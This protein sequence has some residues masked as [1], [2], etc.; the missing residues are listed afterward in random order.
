[1]RL[2]I[3]TKLR[4][5]FFGLAVLFIGFGTAAIVRMSMLN[6]RSTE[7]ET[8]W[9]PSMVYTAALHIDFNQIMVELGRHILAAD[10]AGMA[11][12]DQRI[13]EIEQDIARQRGHYEPLI[14]ADDEAAAYKAFSR[15][16]DEVMVQIRAVLALS[17]TNQKQ[18]A[19][20][21]MKAGEAG[22]NQVGTQLNRLV[23]INRDGAAEEGRA[24]TEI[25]TTTRFRMTGGV[26]LVVALAL[27]LAV[28]LERAVS[29]P[30]AALSEVVG[31]LAEGDL[32]VT[33]EGLERRDEVG[34]IARSVAATAATLQ[35]LVGE[36]R[37]LIG[38]ARA[39]N[40][41][42]RA[43]PGDLKGDYAELLLGTNELLDV[44]TRPLAE[45][46]QVMQ[47]LASGDLK[48]RMTGAYEGDLRALKNNV[49]RS[50]DG[51]VSLLTELGTLAAGMAVGD[52]RRTLK[53]D[54]QG[55]FASLTA[56]FNLA[57]VK[58]RDAL[59]ALVADTAQ[60]SAA[61]SQTTAAARQVAEATAGQMSTLGEI[62]V[63]ISQTAAAVNE[64]SS[65]AGTGS[66]LSRSTAELAASGREMLARLAGEV[67]QIAVRQ[68]SID[69]ITATITRIADKTQVLSINAGIEAAR[70]GEQGRGF[71]VVA[72]EIGRLAEETALAA[73][74]IGALILEAGQ[75]VQRTVTDVAE[76]RRT[77]GRIA[78]EA[79]SA[80]AASNVIAAAISE[81]ASAVH[82]LSQRSDEL[83]QGGE[84]NAAAVEEISVTMEE[85]A[86]MA[87][88]T[89]TE[90]SRFT[91]S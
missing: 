11:A 68:G 19:G 30:I 77:M 82:L 29:R 13:A 37:G 61:V 3:K 44:L 89:R 46:A 70:V 41:S 38:E 7:M 54:Y 66:A 91:L 72:H 63:A 62:S 81:Q 90:M 67:E 53:N 16:F 48:D 83:R 43:E 76:S 5:A 42:V 47:R 65:H 35:R 24:S 21:L 6:A 10:P 58:L 69:R 73:R 39:G 23:T 84:S 2:T 33:V 12:R 1:M 87:H 26:V 56:N 49:N 36:L 45:V 64:V 79:D 27:W 75:G 71:G 80:G 57:V 60:V 59:A 74:D 18:Q 8:N 86:R 15:T 17:R 78:E 52:L 32:Q 28:A 40:L 88:R 14:D 85:L 20:E 9:I 50:L 51:L 34:M 55:E 25:F 31:R 22:F 4:L